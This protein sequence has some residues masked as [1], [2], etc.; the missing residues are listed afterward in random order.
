[1]EED[2]RNKLPANWEARQRQAQWLINDEAARKEAEAKVSQ[3]ITI[4]IIKICH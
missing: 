2:K 4:G 1:M 3:F